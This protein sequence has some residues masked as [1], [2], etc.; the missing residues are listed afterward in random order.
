MFA[1]NGV[2]EG[3][4][5]PP[6]MDFLRRIEGRDRIYNILVSAQHSAGD[7]Y[8]NDLGFFEFHETTNPEIVIAEFAV[9]RKDRITGLSYTMP[10]VHRVTVKNG[11][12]VLFR[13]YTSFQLAPPSVEGVLKT[14]SEV[15][16][17]LDS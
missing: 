8:E 4:C 12:Y 15:A 14:M 7:L 17:E 2:F 3:P 13:D 10:Y 9:I 11:E 16:A 5:A 1:D 6:G